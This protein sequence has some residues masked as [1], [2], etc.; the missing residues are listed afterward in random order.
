MT[1][2]D[3]AIVAGNSPGHTA[4]VKLLLA[5]GA[6]VNTHQGSERVGGCC[7]LMVQPPFTIGFWP[8]E[9]YVVAAGTS[10]YVAAP[11]VSGG[12]GA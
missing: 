5:A 1:P 7:G 2:L 12:L 8:L 3:Y 11:K 6:S 9:G 10:L 4:V